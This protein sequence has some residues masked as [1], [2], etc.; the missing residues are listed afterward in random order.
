MWVD[1]QQAFYILLGPMVVEMILPLF[2]AAG[3]ILALL[4]AVGRYWRAPVT[5][6]MRGWK[7]EE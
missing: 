7:R 4:L 6:E 1:L 2:V 5:I 3:I